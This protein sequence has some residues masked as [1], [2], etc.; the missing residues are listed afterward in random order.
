MYFVQL[1][2]MSLAWLGMSNLFGLFDIEVS[3]KKKNKKQLHEW[4]IL[5]D[6]STRLGLLSARQLG[7]L[8]HYTFVY[9][10]LV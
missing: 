6:M 10:F 2:F 5:L 7:N 1:D 4:L 3:L 9:R 8:V